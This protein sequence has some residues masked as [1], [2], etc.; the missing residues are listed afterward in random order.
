MADMATLVYDIDSSQAAGAARALLQME[1]AA[2]SAETGAARLDRAY[3]G[4]NG[5]F[6]ATADAAKQNEQEIRRL[7]AA[8]NTGLSAQLAFADA[9]REVARAVQLGVVAADQQEAVLAGLAAQYSRTTAAAN[10]Y[11][12]G[13]QGVNNVQASVGNQFAQLNDVMVTAWGGMNPAL[14]GMQQGMQMV[15]G[16]AGQTL[17]QALGTL[18]GAFAQLL[19]PM[20]LL[21]VG[22]IAGGAALIQFG[23]GLIGGGSN[24]KSFADRVSEAQSAI[25]D[26]NKA[27]VTLSRD[28]LEDLVRKYGAVNNQIRQLVENQRLVALADSTKAVRDAVDGLN[29]S[30]GNGMFNTAYGELERVFKVGSNEAQVLYGV[31]RDI[32]ELKSIDQQLAVVESLRDRLS[33]TTQGFKNMTPEQAEM[34]KNLVSAEDII[35]QM[36]AQTDQLGRGFASSAAAASRITDELNRA[37]SAAARL[38]NSAVSDVRMAQIELDF[39]TDD[40]AKAG[41]L[42]A[43]KFD[44]EV[45]KN[46]GIDAG[47]FNRMRAQ[48]IAGAEEAA[49]IQAEV[50][51]LN[52]ADRDAERENNRGAKQ[53]ERELKAAQKGFQTIRE[54]LEKE[55]VFQMAEWERRQ[56]QLDEALKKQLLTEQ[57]YLIMKQQLQQNYFGTEYEQ[58]A[59]RYSMDLE[60][61]KAAREAELLTEQQYMMRRAQLQHEYYSGAITT[62]Q[63]GTAQQLSQLSQHFGQMNQLAGGGYNTLLRAQQTFAAGSALINAY[64][65]A[66]QALADPSVPFWAKAAAYAKTLAAGLGAVNAIKGGGSGGGGGR[67]SSAAASATRAEPQRQVLVRL[68]GD[69]WLVGMAETIMDEIYKQS[70]DGRIVVV[71]DNN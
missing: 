12:T 39:R 53:A 31:I 71:R 58:N 52:K 7:A 69:D 5:R 51:R 22:A 25:D 29:Q 49:R 60:Q 30:L 56:A 57:Q 65:A 40:V 45:G 55:G 42:A 59:L 13:M 18:R 41:A 1:S 8:Y 24:A 26:L 2:A 68:Q 46:T 28:G 37:T 32:G 15:Q 23:A 17:P 67:G 47:I 10:G 64:L 43:A 20:T 27:S 44:A 35:R 61:L 36:V 6:I 21:T 50:E 66:T 38:A 16:F 9:E 34:L 54:L 19:N 14:I 3:R 11:A 70:S 63:N 33:E 48:A 62:D 4:A